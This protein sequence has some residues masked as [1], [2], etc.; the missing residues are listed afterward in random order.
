VLNKTEKETQELSSHP[1]KERKSL[2]ME[3][4]GMDFS[5]TRE[6]H[7]ERNERAIQLYSL[8]RSQQKQRITSSWTHAFHDLFTQKQTKGNM[9]IHT[10]SSGTWRWPREKRRKKIERK[11]EREKKKK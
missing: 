11:K 10:G 8:L 5:F 3:L 7:E 6:E 2:Q 1:K 4:G 9:S